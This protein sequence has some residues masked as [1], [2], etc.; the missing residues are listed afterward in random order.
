MKH[1]ALLAGLDV[2]LGELLLAG[3]DRILKRDRA[4]REFIDRARRAGSHLVAE[5]AQ[6]FLDRGADEVAHLLLCSAFGHP[7]A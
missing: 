4:W 1:G 3:A 6:A 7:L 5:A 2:L